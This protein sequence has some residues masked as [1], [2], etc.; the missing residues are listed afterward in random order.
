MNN[1]L[2]TSILMFLLGLS[3]LSK[4]STTGHGKKD[5][6]SKHDNGKEEGHSEHEHGKE[7]DHSEHDNGKEEGHSEHEHG[8]VEGHSEHEHGHEEEKFGKGKAIEE[9]KKEGKLFKLADGAIKT[10]K[11]DTIQLDRSEKGIYEVPT[12]AIVD[13]QNEVGVYRK[14]GN[15]FEI[16]NVKIIERSKYS[17]R[18][19]SKELSQ[20][21]EIVNQG[22]NLLRVAHLEASGQGGQGHVH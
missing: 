4:A 12:S 9:V 2:I 17:T 10:L 6:H 1:L 7:D 16:I 13:Y 8:K 20:S 21:N 18:I 11:I 22:V 3:T 5:D 14:V 15:W 19:Q